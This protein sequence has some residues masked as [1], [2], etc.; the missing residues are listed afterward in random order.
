MGT[1]GRKSAA[2]LAATVAHLPARPDPPSELT[3]EQA[4]EWREIVRS[5]PVE[6][7]PRETHG[8]LVQFCRH[9]VAG[10]HVARL[11]D[12]VDDDDLPT[13]ARLLRMQALQSGAIA[14]LSTKL[15]L[16]Q[17]A[18]SDRRRKVPA[19]RTPWEWPEG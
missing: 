13:L 17:S 5:M 9:V 8:L 14:S 2:E 7:F 10:R 18:T 6:W 4:K 11:I 15:R 1:R 3:D 19:S 16:A 12:A